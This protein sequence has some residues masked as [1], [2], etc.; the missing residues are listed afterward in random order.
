MTGTLS[1]DVTGIFR[2]I[3]D[4]GAYPAWKHESAAFWMYWD[5]MPQ[6]FV[7]NTTLG[8]IGSNY[9]E[10]NQADPPGPWSP[11]GTY[12]GVPTVANHLG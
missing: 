10:A 11:V 7:L 6:H 9:F 3:A 2:R 1:P 8:V 5:A 12:T 4:H